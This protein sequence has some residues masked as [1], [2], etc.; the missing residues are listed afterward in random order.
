LHGNTLDVP[1]NF[2]VPSPPLLV[3]DRRGVDEN[4]IA[5]REEFFIVGSDDAWPWPGEFE[6][7]DGKFYSV[8][9]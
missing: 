1:S 3:A 8:P 2:K 5:S 7:W 9:F 4:N 6:L